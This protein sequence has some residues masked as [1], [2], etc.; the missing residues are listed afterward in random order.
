MSDKLKEVNCPNCG[1]NLLDKG[2][3]YNP[4]K[5]LTVLYLTRGKDLVREIRKVVR[6]IKRNVPSDDNVRS[7]YFFMKRIESIKDTIVRIGIHR[8]L[9]GNHAY[10]SKGFAYLGR[11]IQYTETNSERQ[12]E[13][14]QKRLGKLPKPQR[15]EDID[16]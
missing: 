15:K 1:H 13:L 16:G 9:E 7:E 8:F 12:Y 2:Y 11:I 14:E 3:D 5:R 10:S 4:R 6:L